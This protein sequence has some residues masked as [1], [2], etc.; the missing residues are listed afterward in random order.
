MFS[1]TSCYIVCQFS[2]FFS[3]TFYKLLTEYAFCI[4]SSAPE[5]IEKL[6]EGTY[7]EAFK[8]GDTVVPVDGD[9]RVNGEIQKVM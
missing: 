2:V 1:C 8:V 6:G 9:L 4:S 7:G 5:S 3:C